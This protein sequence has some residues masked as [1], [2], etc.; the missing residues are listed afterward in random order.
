MCEGSIVVEVLLGPLAGSPK[1][2]R[3]L[4]PGQFAMS[5]AKK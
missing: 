5:S 2:H 4:L 3:T 1:F